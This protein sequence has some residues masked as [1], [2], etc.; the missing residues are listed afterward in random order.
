MKVFVIAVL[1]AQIILATE[2]LEKELN[3]NNQ[4]YKSTLKEYLDHSYTFA[5]RFAGMCEKVLADLK[6]HDEGSAFQSQ[7]AELDDVLRYVAAMKRNENEKTLANMLKLHEILLSAAKEFK[8]T[9]QA[10]QTLIHQLFEKYGAK[11]IVHDFR[12]GFAEYLRNFE[13]NFVEYEQS[14]S[15]EQLE[16]QAKLIQWFKEFK[17]EQSFAK[18]FTSFVTFFKFF[19][20]DLLKNE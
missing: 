18:K 2:V 15:D 10:K 4:F 5:E 1:V 20:P 9:H 3:E 11:A 14:L 17:E 7:K 8:E 13:T 6:Q 12:K 19:A 16:S